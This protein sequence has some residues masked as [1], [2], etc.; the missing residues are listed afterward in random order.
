MKNR[1]K[2]I[3]AKAGKHWCLGCD[4]ELVGKIGK[5]PVCNKKLNKTSKKCIKENKVPL[6]DFG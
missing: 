3:V 6:E 2:Q 5:C 1:D 4:A